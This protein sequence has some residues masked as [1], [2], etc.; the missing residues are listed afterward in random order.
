VEGEREEGKV[1]EIHRGRRARGGKSF[2]DTEGGREVLE[3]REGGPP[4][5]HSI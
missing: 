5:L 4:K 2:R 3:G 1:L